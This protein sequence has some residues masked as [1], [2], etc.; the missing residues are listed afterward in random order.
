M[1]ICGLTK[2][3]LLMT[4]FMASAAIAAEPD[5]S[6]TNQDMGSMNMPS[7]SSGAVKKSAMGDGM[8]CGKPQQSKM[9]CCPMMAKMED[10]GN[11]GGIFGPRVTP[12]MNLSEQ[13]VR[14]YLAVQ[15]DQLNNKR[16]KIGDVKADDR[17]ITADIVTVDNSL[18]QRL[19]VDRRT[20]G[21][22]YKN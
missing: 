12:S 22:E 10:M 1:S 9:G 4:V 5:Q 14:D 20:G 11:S 17:T 3:A 21:I 6:M 16:L 18:V 19:G 8:M 15:L 2:N 7:T 13:D